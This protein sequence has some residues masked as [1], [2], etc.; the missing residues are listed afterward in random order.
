MSLPL[1]QPSGTVG[2]EVNP[3][4][5]LEASVIVAP[6]VYARFHIPG[7]PNALKVNADGLYVK[8]G[9]RTNPFV[10]RMP[11][12]QT[13]YTVATQTDQLINWVTEVFDPD[14]LVDLANFP[15]RMTAPED[16][17]YFLKWSPQVILIGGSAAV[18]S[19]QAF[20]LLNGANWVAGQDAQ[21]L[22]SGG[23]TF[24]GAN[25]EAWL[26]LKA[27]DYIECIW[28]WISF[29]TLTATSMNVAGTWQ[30]WRFDD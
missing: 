25:V 29:T 19:G 13:G 26:D 20:Y 9:R 7:Y 27:G 15:S 1:L 12:Q 24:A 18:A 28:R 8:R 6:V 11:N 23:L 5:E 10:V 4:R 21:G 14:G 30:G 2:L 16:G 17:R 22:V 3:S